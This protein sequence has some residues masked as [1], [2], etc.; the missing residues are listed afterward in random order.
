[1]TIQEALAGSGIAKA[2]SEV[3]LSR[4]LRKDRTW[5]M[6]H[7][8]AVLSDADWTVWAQWVERRRAYEPVAYITQQQEFY[9]RT[10]YVDKRVLIPRSPTEDLVS[11][12]LKFLKN[13]TDTSAEIDTEIIATARRLQKEISIDEVKTLVDIGTG[14]GCIAITLALERP[15]IRVI[16]TDIS[17]QALEVARI[18]ARNLN[19]SD[20]VTF[21][22]GSGLDPLQDLQEPFIIVT[23]PPYIPSGRNLMKDVQDYEPHVALFGGKEGKDLIQEILKAA[24]IHPYCMGVVMECG[25]EQISYDAICLII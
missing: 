12:A 4:L 2:D 11:L 7:P 22:Q 5:L 17:E 21:L 9:G 13:P 10:F 23:N 6:A 20:R 16:A 19:A 8:E 15:D 25:K 3:L 14:S 24:D 1:M 18:N